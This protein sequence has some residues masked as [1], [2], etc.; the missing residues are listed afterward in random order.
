MALVEVDG[1]MILLDGDMIKAEPHGRDSIVII[2][3]IIVTQHR[4]VDPILDA[5]MFVKIICE[6]SSDSHNTELVPK[7]KVARNYICINF[8][9]NAMSGILVP[10]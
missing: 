9:P 4:K 8:Q 6:F 7:K 10:P 2:I 5:L 3:I 1:C